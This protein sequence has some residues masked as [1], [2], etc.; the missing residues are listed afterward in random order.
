ME[1]IISFLTQITRAKLIP[2]L[3]AVSLIVG[4]IVSQLVYLI[5]PGYKTAE[6][7]TVEIVEDAFGAIETLEIVGVTPFIDFA[8]IF[9]VFALLSMMIAF[10]ETLIFQFILLLT[11][12]KLSDWIAKSSY[13]APS[14]VITS[15]I[16]SFYHVM[17]YDQNYYYG[18]L[19][20]IIVLLPC[21]SFTI[22]AIVEIERRDGHPILAVSTLHFLYILAIGI[23]TLVSEGY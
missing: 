22:L 5:E 21:F 2:A 8:L 9:V 10:L 20:A 7:A 13:W 1:H 4:E 14:F 15:L 6:P 18:L 3:L 17:N 16:F 12:K 23:V 11:I 19:H